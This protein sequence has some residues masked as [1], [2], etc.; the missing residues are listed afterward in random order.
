MRALALALALLVA[1]SWAAAQTLV[2]LGASWRY[3]DDGSDQGSAWQAPGF[4]DTGWALGAAELG[5]G[6]GD[7]A[8]VVSFGGNASDKHITSYFRHHFAVADP[9]TVPALELSI[10][11]DDGAVVYLNGTEVYRSNLPGGAIDSETLALT[12]VSGAG[13]SELHETPVFPGLLVPGDNVLAVEIH[14]SGPTSSD[15]SFNLQLVVGPPP[16]PPSLLRQPYLQVGTPHGVTVRWRTDEAVDSIVKFGAAPNSL[17]SQVSIPGTRTEH[18]V[19]ISGLDPDTRYFYSVG[20]TGMTLA[21]G[22]ADHFFDTSPLPGTPAPTRIWVIGDSGQ[23]ALDNQGCIDAGLVR[24][25]YLAWAGAD[26]ADVWL[27]LGDNAYNTGTDSEYQ[28]AV[29][30]IYGELL[31]TS[32]LWPTRG[33]HD[34]VFQGPN[35]DYYDIFTMPTAGEAGGLASGTEAYYSYDY[36]DIHFI[37]LDSEGSDLTVGSAMFTWLADDLAATNQ[38]WIIAYWH[39]P[40]YTKGSHDSDNANDS[41]GRMRDMRLN[42]LPILEAGGV[43]LVFSGHSHSY[44]RSFL[45]DGHYGISTTLQD[46]NRVDDGDGSVR[47]GGAYVKP[48][49]YPAPNEGAV[50]TTAGSSSK[51]GGGPLNHPVMVTSLNVL[52]SVVLDIDGNQLDAVFLD[53]NG[54]VKDDYR[55]IKAPVGLA[56][57]ASSGELGAIDNRPNPFAGRTRFTY[58]LPRAGRVRLAIHDVQGRQIATLEDG[59][60]A[61]GE[62]AAVWDGRGANGRAVAGGVYFSR[63]EFEGDVR[64]KKL[65]VVR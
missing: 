20:S 38:D 31:R 63:L 14:Q 34:S 7:E 16:G 27:I 1:P 9:N 40:P 36:A 8:T 59:D 24:D 33:N 25:E 4:V 42:A 29:F 11:R 2:P 32:A 12:A 57:D 23:C 51:I 49:P 65:I 35:N 13:E 47:G 45:L 6:D 28:A 55:I 44:E 15:I 64:T 48:S 60:R 53:D 52:G 56:A 37:C 10:L 21:G 39:H 41:G 22:D 30:D 54:T 61:A 62:H 17:L 18:Q 5:Y 19:P 58:S 26:T 50:F 46:S 43:D 3:L